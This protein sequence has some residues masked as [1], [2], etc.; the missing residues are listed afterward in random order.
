MKKISKRRSTGLIHIEVDRLRG[1]NIGFGAMLIAMVNCLPA[2]VQADVVSQIDAALE[3]A[4]G[5]LEGNPDCTDGELQ[6]FLH[7]TSAFR[8]ALG[9]KYDSTQRAN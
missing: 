3:H 2:N 6:G 5:D 8:Y 9:L 4:R 1:E 7:V